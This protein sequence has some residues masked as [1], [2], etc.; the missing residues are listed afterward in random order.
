[1]ALRHVQCPRFIFFNFPSLQLRKFDVNTSA[2]VSERKVG[3][4]FFQ[5][6]G[7][8]FLRYIYIAMVY[9][10]TL[11]LGFFCNENVKSEVIK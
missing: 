6:P 4:I 9:W 8:A 11:P 1:M 5:S 7:M 2:L 3:A 10:I